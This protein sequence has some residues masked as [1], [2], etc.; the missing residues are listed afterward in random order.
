ME[1][2]RGHTGLQAPTQRPLHAH[3]SEPNQNPYP[4]ACSHLFGREGPPVP[5]GTRTWPR[6]QAGHGKGP[7][8]GRGSADRDSSHQHRW[9]LEGERTWF[10]GGAPR[11]QT[12][13][14]PP[15]PRPASR[16][17]KRPGGH[18][19]WNVP[20]PRARHGAPPRQ[21]LGRQGWAPHSPTPTLRVAAPRQ[22]PSSKRWLLTSSR[23]MQPLS[24][25]LTEV[26]SNTLPPG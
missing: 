10:Q 8:R 6:P 3:R 11:P 16:S 20:P 5:G 12:H 13:R 9:G 19:Q 17:P 25:T 18:W 23:R 1:D 22:L 24:P 2:E 26:R 21:G 14:C 7:P 15:A 4:H